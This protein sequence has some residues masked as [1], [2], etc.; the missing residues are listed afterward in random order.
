MTVI[1]NDETNKDKDH[2]P[3]NN[4]LENYKRNKY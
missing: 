3:V 1:F 4:C 2:S